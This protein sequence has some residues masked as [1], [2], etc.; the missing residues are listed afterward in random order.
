MRD[1]PDRKELTVGKLYELMGD[2]LDLE[3]VNGPSGHDRQVASPDISRPG[4][5]LTG[6]LHKFLHERIQIFG[7][8][9]KSYLDSLSEEERNSSL[10]SL[11]DFPVYCS[12]ITKGL[13]PP[14]ELVRLSLSNSAALFLSK[15]DTTP[16]IH[17]LA[18]FLDLVFAPRT[19]VYGTLVE[20][21]GAGLLCTGRSA[22][23]KSETVLGLIERG[24]RL[25]ADDMVHVRRIGNA[26]FGTG[27]SRMAHHME[28]RGLG[29]VDVSA[30]Y[31]IRSIKDRQQI[32]LEVKLEEWSKENQDFDRTGLVQQLS[33]ILD[34]PI[35]R[36]VIPV[37]P[38]R[39]LTLLLEVAVM[40]YLLLQKGRNVPEEVERD[41]IERIIRKETESGMD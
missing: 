24:H 22:I 37:L 13:E 31:G 32:H 21:F 19:D 41:L 38:G 39:N 23:G 34:I 30:F 15:R 1:I 20:V 10:R 7:E 9:E 36:T 6:Y 12:I 28:I 26:I 16:L 17:D 5:A 8:T 35:P 29:L 14:E 27:D 25:I 2:K 33:T 4:M 11:F 40:N 18:D 3:P